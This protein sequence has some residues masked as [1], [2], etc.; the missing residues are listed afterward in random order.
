MFNP[1]NGII[2]N[3]GT[4]IAIYTFII[5]LLIAYKQ[6]I[7]ALIGILLIPVFIACRKN[8]QKKYLEEM[9]DKIQQAQDDFAAGK[10]V[11]PFLNI[12]AEP[13]QIIEL[14]PGV[15]RMQAKNLVFQ[16]RRVRK[17]EKFEEFRKIIGLNPALV[18]VN[19]Q[20]VKFD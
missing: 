10:K 19:K 9:K 7:Y 12:N 4:I 13:W 6:F 15:S 11:E 18:E 17:V 20:I 2:S 16:I 1:K 8:F 5:T 14:L 3:M